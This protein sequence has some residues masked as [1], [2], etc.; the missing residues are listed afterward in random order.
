MLQASLF[1]RFKCVR[2][3]KP[4][5]LHKFHRLCV[6][7]VRLCRTDPKIGA[8]WLCCKRNP[9]PP[10]EAPP[11][12]AEKIKILR[13]RVLRYQELHHKDDPRKVDWTLTNLTELFSEPQQRTAG[14]T[15]VERDGNRYRARPMAG[16][17]KHNLGEFDTEG[18]AVAK[19]EAFWLDWLGLPAG[20]T[21]AELEAARVQDAAAARIG[22]RERRRQRK[23]KEA[24]EE[25]TPLFG[26]AKEFA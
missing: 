5:K 23:S 17:V 16:G 4:A 9:P 18:E 22:A 8:I 7:C 13:Q 24:A 19:V 20:S 12:S 11:G 3:R 21:P 10:T 14:K 25:V 1:T 26:P 2:C 15:G 6:E